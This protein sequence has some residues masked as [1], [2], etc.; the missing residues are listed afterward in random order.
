MS[1]LRPRPVSS[2]INHVLRSAPLAMQRLRRHAGRTVEFH[3]GP[4]RLA[5]TVQT[6]GEVL[7]AVP[8]AA[9]DLEVTI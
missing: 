1:P 8:E 5:F 6:T 3:V 7:P 2:A 4:A 9:R